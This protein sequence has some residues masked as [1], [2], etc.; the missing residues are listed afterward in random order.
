MVV[1]RNQG[2][3]APEFFAAV[4]RAVGP[5]FAQALAGAGFEGKAGQAVLVHTAGRIKPRV[6]VAVG[7]GPPIR[8]PRCR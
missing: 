1:F 2:G 3:E 7:L 8:P 4:G 6:V 5:S